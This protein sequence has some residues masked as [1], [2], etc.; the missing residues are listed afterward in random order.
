MNGSVMQRHGDNIYHRDLK[1]EQWIQEDSFHSQRGG[2]LDT[3]NLRIDTG[4][5]DRVL[6]GYWF[7]YWGGDGPPIPERFYDFVHKGIGNHYVNDETRIAEFVMWATDQGQLGVNGD[8][9]EWKVMSTAVKRR[10]G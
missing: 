5:T 2:V 1:T 7:I 6:I 3:D 4:S 10:A 9:A 8:P